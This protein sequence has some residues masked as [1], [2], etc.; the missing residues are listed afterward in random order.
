M[1]CDNSIFSY[2]YFPFRPLEG[3]Y[4]Y[5]CGKYYKEL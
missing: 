2:F 1:K 4:K 3:N 5:G